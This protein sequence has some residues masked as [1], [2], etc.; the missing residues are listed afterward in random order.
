MPIMYRRWLSGWYCIDSMKGRRMRRKCWRGSFCS[1][2]MWRSIRLYCYKREK[3]ASGWNGRPESNFSMLWKENLREVT[4]TGYKFARI[5]SPGF[6]SLCHLVLWVSFFSFK[7]KFKNRRAKRISAMFTDQD[8]QLEVGS[9]I[10]LKSKWIIEENE[11]S[12]NN[13]LFCD[14]NCLTF[15][16]KI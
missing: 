3:P 9:K 2:W 10:V 6:V 1:F 11:K 7:V 15:L 14:I 5:V 4:F 12:K 8:F 13:S 16:L